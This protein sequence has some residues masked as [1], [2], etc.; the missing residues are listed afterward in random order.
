M[1]NTIYCQVVFALKNLDIF[2]HWFCFNLH[3]YRCVKLVRIVWMFIPYENM[4][5]I[6]IYQHKNADDD[7]C[8][9]G[10]SSVSLLM[11]NAAIDSVID[12]LKYKMIQVKPSWRCSL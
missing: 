8:R 1:H 9:T 6:R 2:F 11:S 10:W 4:W 12:G 7:M 3:H 5:E